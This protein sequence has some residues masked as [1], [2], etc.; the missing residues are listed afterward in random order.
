[1][2]S[3]FFLFVFHVTTFPFTIHIKIYVCII[4]GN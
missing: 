4:I 3:V 2:Y 1:M